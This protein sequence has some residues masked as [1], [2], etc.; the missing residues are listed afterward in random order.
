M[1]GEG[2]ESLMGKFPSVS[3]VSNNLSSSDSSSNR[4]MWAV[5]LCRDNLACEDPACPLVRLS[6]R[7]TPPMHPT[8]PLGDACEP[9]HPVGMV[10]QDAAGRMS[11]GRAYTRNSS[12]NPFCD[13][14]WLMHAHTHQLRYSCEPRKSGSA[15]TSITIGSVTWCLQLSYLAL[16]V[17]CIG[18]QT[19][20]PLPVV[21]RKES[22]LAGSTGIGWSARSCIITWSTCTMQTRLNHTIATGECHVRISG[23]R[24]IQSVE[25]WAHPS[26]LDPTQ[27]TYGRSNSSPA[28]HS[29][30][31]QVTPNQHHQVAP[32]ILLQRVIVCI[33]WDVL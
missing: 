9:M 7:T 32:D 29:Q 1:V 31:E 21:V 33:M 17:C 22:K 14:N 30:P 19:Y 16:V 8:L 4:S 24:R 3:K 2:G 6:R 13:K 27:R 12:S 15:T 28:A 23:Q 5:Y 10:C 20:S 25:T 18:F 26:E 11:A